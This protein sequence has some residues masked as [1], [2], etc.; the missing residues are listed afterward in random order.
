LGATSPSSQLLDVA[1][2]PCPKLKAEGMIISMPIEDAKMLRR[3]NRIDA[4]L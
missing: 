2:R 4:Q 3:G 1:A